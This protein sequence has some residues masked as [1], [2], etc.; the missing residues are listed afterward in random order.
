MARE[1]TFEVVVFGKRDRLLKVLLTQVGA[2]ECTSD[3]CGLN[4]VMGSLAPAVLAEIPLIE[5]LEP[6]EDV[7]VRRG[8]VSTLAAGES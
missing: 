3:S 2:P 4:A 8:R 7:G 1:L 5:R 6:L